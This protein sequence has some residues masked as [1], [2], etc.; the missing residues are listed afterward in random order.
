MLCLLGMCQ[1]AGPFCLEQGLAPQ[2]CSPCHRVPRKGEGCPYQTPQ[3]L[4][5][6]LRGFAQWRGTRG[7]SGSALATSCAAAGDKEL[8]CW[9]HNGLGGLAKTLPSISAMGSGRSY[10]VVWFSIHSPSNAIK[11]SFFTSPAFHIHPPLQPISNQPLSQVDTCFLFFFF[12]VKLVAY[13]CLK[14]KR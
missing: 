3:A 4:G 8:M 11:T 2:E 7:V 6:S 13:H 5:E 10:G 14:G 9:D 12:D 1:G